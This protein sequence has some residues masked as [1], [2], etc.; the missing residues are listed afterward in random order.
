MWGGWALAAI[1]GILA[2]RANVRFDVND[3]LKE[4]RKR[5]EGNLCSLCPHVRRGEKDGKPVI[6]STYISP[7]GTVAIQYQMYGHITYDRSAMQQEV[8]YWAQNPSALSER[9]N[10]AEKLREKLGWE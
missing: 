1:T 6:H 3:Y 4:R 7:P 9:E 10:K 8:Q 5:V 2:L